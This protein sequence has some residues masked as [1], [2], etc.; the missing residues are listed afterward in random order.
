MHEHATLDQDGAVVKAEV[1]VIILLGPAAGAHEVDGRQ[2]A[3]EHLHPPYSR[4]WCSWLAGSAHCLL[5]Q[6]E[7]GLVWWEVPKHPWQSLL[8]HWYRDCLLVQRACL[9]NHTI[10]GRTIS[11]DGNI[12]WALGPHSKS[13]ANSPAC[14]SK[15]APASRWL[16]Q[17]QCHPTPVHNRQQHRLSE[18]NGRSSNSTAP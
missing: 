11:I 9:Q 12:T 18:R 4:Q 1:L 10:T 17:G 6:C 7:P 15:E 14:Q 2:E 8:Q 13:Q 5:S 16:A 3:A